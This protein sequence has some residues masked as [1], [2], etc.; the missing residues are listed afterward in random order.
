M[1]ITFFFLSFFSLIILFQ[2]LQTVGVRG[3]K[4]PF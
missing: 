3:K 2:L 1:E 4:I